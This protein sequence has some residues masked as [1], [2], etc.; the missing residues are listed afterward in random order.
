M[1]ETYRITINNHPFRFDCRSWGTRSGFAH[2]VELWDTGEWDRLA[3]AK[4]F[5][6]NRT[7]ECYNFQTVML[8]AIR[9][10]QNREVTRTWENLQRLYGWER[11]TKKRREELDKRLAEDEYMETLKA[12]YDEVKKVHPAW[13]RWEWVRVE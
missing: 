11:I 4:C 1:E 9:K 6:L 5:Y 8:E 2:G 13:E 3:E 7:W 10:A 12:L